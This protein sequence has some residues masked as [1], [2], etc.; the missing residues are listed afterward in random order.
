MQ[1]RLP[2]ARLTTAAALVLA[3]LMAGAPSA[4]GADDP[5]GPE[6]EA[7]FEVTLT[8][9]P[10]TT[11]FGHRTVDLTGTVTEDDGTPVADAPVKLHESVQ[12]DTWNPWYDPIDPT[13][14][15]TRDLGTVRTDAEGRF[16]LAD[17][18][19]DRW[20]DEPSPYLFPSNEVQFQASYDPGDPNDHHFFFAHHT[21]AVE[22]VAGAITYKVNRTRVQ[23]GDHLVVTGKVSW[24]A[25]HGP[26]A[27][28]RVLLR[29]Y[30][31]SAYNAQTT[32]DAQGNFLVQTRIRDYDNEFVLFSAPKD[33]YMAGA[34]ADLPVKN[35]TP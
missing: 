3:T 20:E 13:E 9:S 23:A 7:P 2:A 24:P 27:G 14:R 26:V 1:M 12:Y 19:A 16:S 15:E 17:V 29:T 30:W 6:P 35:V 18:R 8:S 10:A 22:P 11:D 32:T 21:V 25:G 5:P 33:Y 31:E 34:S 28:P 4:Q